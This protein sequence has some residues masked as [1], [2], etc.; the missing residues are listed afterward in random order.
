METALSSLQVFKA[1][2]YTGSNTS[3]Y[4]DMDGLE[5]ERR[6]SSALAMELRLS[7]TNHQYSRHVHLSIPVLTYW[8]MGDVAVRIKA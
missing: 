8:P 6:N 1:V 2:S 3:S 4:D 5:Q 7:C